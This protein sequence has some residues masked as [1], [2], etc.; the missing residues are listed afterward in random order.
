MDAERGEDG[1]AQKRQRIEGAGPPTRRTAS[2]LFAPF[3]TVGLVSPTA[4]PFTS[5]P[6][7]KTTFQITTSVGRTLQTYDIKRGLNLVFLTRPQTPGQ[8]TATTAWNDKV[9]AAWAVGERRGLWIYKRGKKV[10]ELSLPASLVND[11]SQVTVFGTWIVACSA[12]GLEVWN[13]T[14]LQHHAS[15]EPPAN[16]VFSGPIAT[17]PTLLNK[18]MI[19]CSDGRVQ[20]WNVSTGKLLYNLHSLV[21]TVGAVVALQPATA[22]NVLAISYAD[23]TIVLHDVRTDRQILR[24]AAG[25][26]AS[27]V[28]SISFRTDGLG[29]GTDGQEDGVMATASHKSGDITFWDLNQG[30]RKM[31]VLRSAHNP[32][33]EGKVAGGVS[34]IEFLPGQAIIVSSGLDNTLKSWIFDQMPYSPIPRILHQRGGHAAPVT[35]LDFLPSD[36]DGTDA[37]GKW[38]L[39][40]SQDRSFWGWSLRRDGQSSELSQGAVRKKAKKMGVLSNGTEDGNRR[41]VHVG[42]EDLKVP[43]VT[44]MAC[45]LNRDGG[46]G[47]LPGERNI[48]TNGRSGDG[49]KKGPN[50]TELSATTGWESIVTGH[51]G[52]KTAR[53]WFWGRRRAGRWAFETGDGGTVTAVAMS[54]CGT[55]ALVGS[56][57][58]GIDMFNLQSGAHRQ[59]FPPRLTPIQAKRLKAQQADGAVKSPSEQSAKFKRGIG[60][61]TKAVT[62][63]VVD[64]INSTIVSCGADG[65]IKFWDFATGLLLKQLDWSSITTVVGLKLHRSSDLLAMSCTDGCLRVIDIATKKLVRELWGSESDIADFCF[66]NDGRWLIAVSAASHGSDDRSVVRIWD[67]PT[68]HM[69]DAFR[70]H[71]H[72]RSLAFSNTGEFLATASSDNVGVD[73]WTNR[74][75]FAHVSTRRILP[76]DVAD[77]SQVPSANGE[78]GQGLLDTAFEDG[79]AGL[80]EDEEVAAVPGVDQLSKELVTLSLVPKAQWQTLLH[81]DLVRERNKPIEPPKA[82]E[83]APFFL[84]SLQDAPAS[85]ALVPRQGPQSGDHQSRLSKAS[86]LT[87]ATDRDPFTVLLHQAASRPSLLTSEALTSYLASLGPAAADLAIR[88]L[89]ISPPYTEMIVF[90]KALTARMR[91]RR[92]FELVVVWMSVWVRCHSGLLLADKET[93]DDMGKLRD[94]L[95]EW[96][97]SAT[98][99]S[100]RLGKL[101]GLVGGVLG[102]VRDVV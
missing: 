30:G 97:T 50:S 2:V 96:K 67:L 95:R 84:P 19:G 99:E 58:G 48:W 16:L 14:T 36:F 17:M 11:V 93:D 80:E 21:G 29:A 62:G 98:E 73:I 63:L 3:R 56:S 1:R 10:Q 15:I 35:R 89:D 61:H 37:G 64:N 38:L 72:C 9:L 82:P 91:E 49:K 6:L 31:G 26:S 86:S 81:L 12:S 42:L 70:L 4:V 57:N 77:L 90:V 94:A 87:K 25:T 74:T 83:K 102:W 76:E 46:M 22:L 24:F 60:K 13:T 71:G 85:K 52:D 88:N 51:E 5:V 32:P 44:C 39:S 28:T 33:V 54:P 65:K 18:V 43:P 100:K 53:T 23:G 92:D 78:G 34:G 20:V 68:S 101:V 27:P 41:S 7:G 8:I 47:A 45:S 66:S 69:I 75:L 59:R 55:F 40:G 79:A